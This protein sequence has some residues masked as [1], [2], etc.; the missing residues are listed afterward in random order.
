MQKDKVIAKNIIIYDGECGFCNR[1]I[2]FIAKNDTENA[3]SFTPN[4]S[5]LAKSIFEKEKINPKLSEET[6]FLQTKEILYTKGKAIKQIFKRIP[7]Y[8]WIYFLLMFINRHL[9]DLGYISFSRIRKKI[10]L[11]SCK[12]PSKQV[13]EKFI[14]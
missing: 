4:N 3:F 6:I 14:F 1:F 2:L 7:K 8:K 11:N 9:I 13:T 5:D 12:I 10:L